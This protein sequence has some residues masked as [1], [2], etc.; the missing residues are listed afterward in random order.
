MITGFSLIYRLTILAVSIGV[1]FRYKHVDKASKIIC[2]LI[3]LGLITESIGYYAAKMYRNNY[4]VFNIAFF[5]EFTLM[6][7]YFGYSNEILR[8]KKMGIYIAL[9]GIALGLINTFS[10]QPLSTTLNSHFLFLEC[11][12]VMSLA[13]LSFHHLLVECDENMKLQRMP[14]FWFPCILLFYQCATLST[15]GMY[16]K[17]GNSDIEK[18]AA[19]DVSVLSINIITYLSYAAVFAFYP[20][21]KIYNDRP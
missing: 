5:V 16:D 14:H 2:W 13:A 18:A 20:K 1:I 12:V 6:S 15:W 21:M 17:L 11:L 3:W 8:K 19:L 9:S 4:P 10:F 7:L